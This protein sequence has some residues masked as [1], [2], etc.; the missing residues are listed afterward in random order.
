[1]RS[2]AQA[3]ELDEET[4]KH[5]DQA[6]QEEQ[7]FKPEPEPD[8]P[9]PSMSVEREAP[10]PEPEV[11]ADRPRNPDGTFAPKDPEAKAVA[12]EPSKAAEKPAE[13]PKEQKTPEGYVPHGA[14]HEERARR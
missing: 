3:F 2:I 6:R 5:M 1:M 4:T 12:K 7:T 9:A 14:L 11:V 10:A 8:R 13:A